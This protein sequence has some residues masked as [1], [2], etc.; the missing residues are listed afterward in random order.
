MISP[1]LTKLY[2]SI[3]EKKINTWIE[4]HGKRDRGQVGFRGYHSTVDHLVTFR[5]IAEECRNDK[6]DLLCCF[7]DF[8][9]TFLTLFLGLTSR[10]RLEGS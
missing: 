1:I 9:K 3:L 6:I 8:I 5:I 10:N 7:I 4:S 2:G